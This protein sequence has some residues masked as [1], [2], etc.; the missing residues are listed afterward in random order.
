[1]SRYEWTELYLPLISY[2]NLIG[3]N[4]TCVQ[5]YLRSSELLFAFEVL[6]CETGG[7]RRKTGTGRPSISIPEIAER[8]GKTLMCHLSQQ[9]EVPSR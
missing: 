2:G 6:F 7:V 1:M 9:M 5:K 3:A 4:V 8:V